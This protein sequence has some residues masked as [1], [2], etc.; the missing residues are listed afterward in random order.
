MRDIYINLNLKDLGAQISRAHGAHIRLDARGHVCKIIRYHIH[1][2]TFYAIHCEP[3]KW[4]CAQYVEKLLWS[5]HTNQSTQPTDVCKCSN[6]LSYAAISTP[7]TIL[8]NE[9]TLHTHT[10]K[11]ALARPTRIAHNSIAVCQPTVKPCGK[12]LAARRRTNGRRCFG[13]CMSPQRRHV[14]RRVKV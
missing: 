13:K 12:F 3:N 2:H 4:H 5:T 10:H 8:M 6:A 9:H 11:R 14:R 7:R 1:T